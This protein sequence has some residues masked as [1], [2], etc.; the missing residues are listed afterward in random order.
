[1][2]A[3]I[4][5]M[6]YDYGKKERGYS[7]EYY[8]V[9]LPFSN[10]LGKE[11]VL[12]FDF[13]SEFLSK[14]KQVM[15]KNLLNFITAEKPDITVFC[16]FENE[17]DE[18]IISELRSHTKTV[19]YFFDD[20]WRQKYVRHWIKYFDFFTSPD[21]YTYKGYALD[22]INNAIYSPFG[23]NGEV[24]VKR[25][26]PIRY[27]VSFVGG[28]SPLRKWII[29]L[30]QK[31]NI[32]VNVFGRNWGRGIQ[33]VSQEEIVNIF[34]QSKIN[35]NLSN[36]ISHDMNYLLWSLSSLRAMRYN[37]TNKK[38]K[39]Q[40][41]GRHFEINA[42]GGFQLSYFVPGLNSVYEIDKEI[43]VFDEIRNLPDII[44]FFL[45]NDKLRTQ[46]ANKGYERSL[47]EH[48]SGYYIQNILDKVF[49]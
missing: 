9:F 3:V 26:I 28:Y 19:A 30:L 4:V 14:G 17:F 34:N 37:L 42:C 21:Y 13:Y 47:K 29:H 48:K 16:L 36:G 41:K 24:Y 49:K 33:Y 11:N 2:K 44:K 1:M 6:Q 23:F 32:E 27:D 38:N 8:N 43:A 25:N 31:N 45:R 5:L 15:N 7:Y 39:E 35:L 46:I 12:L 20:P 10:V 40:V 22:G 18:K